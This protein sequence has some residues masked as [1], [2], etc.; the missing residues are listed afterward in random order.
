MFCAFLIVIAA[1]A[2]GEPAA[3]GTAA[4][5]GTAVEQRTQ[6]VPVLER[7]AVAA[8]GK[9]L[10]RV[11]D[12]PASVSRVQLDL[13][14]QVLEVTGVKIGNPKGF[15]GG[16]Q[17]IAVDLVRVE[18]DPKLLFGRE[19]AI[20]LVS[21]S[22]TTVNAELG[23]RGLNLKTLLDNAGRRV[24]KGLFEG[25]P[26]KRFKIEKGVLEK[27][28]VNFNAALLGQNS[29]KEIGPLEISLMGRDN[30]GVTANEAMT[31]I[32]KTLIE[33]TGLLD[34]GADGIL[35]PIGDLLGGGNR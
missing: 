13:K 33:E 28:I 25:D 4:P 1:V 6:D 10:S 17:A 11:L 20:R 32:L 16:Q 5:G 18:A 12:A 34:H 21:V 9:V 19:P 35:G 30:K 2:A 7:V 29:S 24:P 22:G 27:G 3:E 31:T 26:N 23:L 14:K 8:I 15:D